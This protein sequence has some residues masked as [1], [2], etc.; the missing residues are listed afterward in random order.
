MIQTLD[1]FQFVT[2]VNVSSFQGVQSN[3]AGT[4]MK[5]T[6]T[7]SS[8]GTG[9]GWDPA[10]PSPPSPGTDDFGFSA[11]PGGCRWNDGTFN[12]IRGIALFWSATGVGSTAWYREL[13]SISG[14]VRRFSTS[15]SFGASVR[16]LKD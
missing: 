8:S 16:C 5:S 6:V 12:A 13:L 10:S 11:L 7:N 15:K 4:V 2:S 1:P 3:T 9:L 14:Q